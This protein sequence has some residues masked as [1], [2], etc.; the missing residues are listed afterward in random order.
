MKD[1]CLY[2]HDG[3][4]QTLVLAG[5]DHG[6][7]SDGSDALTPKLPK[8]FFACCRKSRTRRALNLYAALAIEKRSVCYL[9]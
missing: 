5:I 2:G 1:Q 4:D 3:Y 6:H 8:I 9:D 7:Y